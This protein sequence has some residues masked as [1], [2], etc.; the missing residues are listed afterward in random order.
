MT[1]QAL[2]EHAA[3][4]HAPQVGGPALEPER[5]PV[6]RARRRDAHEP[7]LVWPVLEH[8][9]DVRGVTAQ[10]ESERRSALAARA[11]EREHAVEQIAAVQERREL[12][13]SGQQLRP[14]DLGERELAT[15]GCEVVDQAPPTGDLERRPGSAVRVV[16]RRIARLLRGSTAV[17]AKRWK[18]RR[19]PM[20]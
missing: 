13:E 19:T 6:E 17:V 11:V 16:G 7:T 18:D 10:H 5:V 8:V 12:V 9:C 1:E 3:D 20:P 14:G 4:Q 2:R 15:R